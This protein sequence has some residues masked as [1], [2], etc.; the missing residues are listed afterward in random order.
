MGVRKPTEFAAKPRGAPGG[1]FSGS[2]EQGVMRVGARPT[3]RDFFEIGRRGEDSRQNWWG[4]EEE[5]RRGEVRR[6]IGKLESG[7]RR[8]RR[9]QAEG[10]NGKSARVLCDLLPR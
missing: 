6:R 4:R 9:R 5:E 1:E 8:I 3:R 7:G 10:G 2:N